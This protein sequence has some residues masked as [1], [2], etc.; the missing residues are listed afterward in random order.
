MKKLLFAAIA[1]MALPAMVNAHFLLE[2][3]TDTMIEKT[4][5]CAGQ[6]DLLAPVRKRPCHGS[7]KAAGIL[8]DPQR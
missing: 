1:A 4:R 6:A 3:T 5:R 8:C 2:Y 7:G